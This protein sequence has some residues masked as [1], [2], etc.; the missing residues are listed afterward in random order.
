MRIWPQMDIPTT[1]EQKEAVFPYMTQ[2]LGAAHTNLTQGMR[3]NAQVV[4]H[5]LMDTTRNTH[6]PIVRL[7]RQ[8]LAHH[9]CDLVAHRLRRPR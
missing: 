8:V 3:L 2:K 4:L 7:G 9:V 6:I 5:A 1:K